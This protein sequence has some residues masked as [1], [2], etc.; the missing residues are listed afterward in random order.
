MRFHVQAT[1]TDGFAN[2]GTEEYQLIVKPDQLPTVTIEEPRGII[3]AV[4]MELD[5]QAKTLKLKSAVRGS[6][7]PT[8]PTK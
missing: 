6:L 2:R 3:R 4:G 5:T 1:D 8:P 7:Q